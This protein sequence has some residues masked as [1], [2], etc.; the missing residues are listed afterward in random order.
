MAVHTV[1]RAVSQPTPAPA[2]RTPAWGQISIL[3]IEI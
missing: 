3:E 2:S 1:A